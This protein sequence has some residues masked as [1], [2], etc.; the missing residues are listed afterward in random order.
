[1]AMKPHLIASS[2]VFF[3][4]RGKLCARFDCVVRTNLSAA[5]AFDAEIGVDVVDFALRDSL[6]GANGQ[7]SSASDATISDYVSHSFF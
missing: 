6:Y 3:S 1:M 4:E 5:T 2:P 7:T